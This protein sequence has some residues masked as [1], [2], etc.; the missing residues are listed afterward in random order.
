MEHLI[1]KVSE[2]F[3]IISEMNDMSNIYFYFLGNKQTLPMTEAT[4]PSW[5]EGKEGVLV[6]CIQSTGTYLC[7]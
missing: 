2:T 3:L 1:T 5:M 6:K 7:N 4:W